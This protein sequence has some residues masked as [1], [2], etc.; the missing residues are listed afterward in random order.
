MPIYRSTR[1]TGERWWVYGP[2]MKCGK[3]S[4]HC[5]VSLPPR[6]LLRNVQA[7]CKRKQEAQLP[8]RNSA[9]A[10]HVYLGWLTD[11]AMHRTPQNRRGCIISWHSIARSAGRKRLLTWNS[12]SRSFKVIHFAIS[13]RPTRGSVSSYNIACHISEVFEDVA[14]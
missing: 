5:M 8:Q 11:H 7:A 1:E 3:P 4:G 13:Y 10:A 9:S 6:K 2:W 14:T 12:H